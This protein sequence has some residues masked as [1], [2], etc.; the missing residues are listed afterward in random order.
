M[1]RVEELELYDS[2][3]KTIEL[4]DK[5]VIRAKFRLLEPL[6]QVY[7]IIIHIRGSPGRIVAFKALTK[8]LIPIDNYTR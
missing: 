5:K 1:I 3:D 2:Q 6:D 4:T 8:R 7:N